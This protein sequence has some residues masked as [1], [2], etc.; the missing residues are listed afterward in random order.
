[1]LLIKGN[2]VPFERRNEQTENVKDNGMIADVYGASNVCLT[3]SHVIMY[4][5]VARSRVLVGACDVW[6][7][8]RNVFPDYVEARHLQ[9]KRVL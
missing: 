8:Y 1:M 5:N 4:S 9:L 6:T 3:I 2:V 7:W